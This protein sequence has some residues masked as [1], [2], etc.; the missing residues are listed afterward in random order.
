MQDG[1]QMSDGDVHFAWIRKKTSQ[2]TDQK[3]K[4]SVRYV[5]Y[6]YPQSCRRVRK[7]ISCKAPDILPTLKIREELVA[8]I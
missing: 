4:P 7:R 6:C 3:I 2:D 8:H 5:R 1:D